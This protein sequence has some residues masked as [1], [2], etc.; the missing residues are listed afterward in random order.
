MMKAVTHRGDDS[1]LSWP[2]SYQLLEA[3]TSSSVKQSVAYDAELK[4]AQQCAERVVLESDLEYESG[5][6]LPS[7][8]HASV[9]S[10]KNRGEQL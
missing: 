1:G 7:L 2:F 8:P 5:W 4:A 9:S 6:A 3:P 10:S